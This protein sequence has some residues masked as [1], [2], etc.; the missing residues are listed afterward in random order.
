MWAGIESDASHVDDLIAMGFSGIH[1]MQDRPLPIPTKTS[2]LTN[3]SGFQTAS[4]VNTAISTAT[5]ALQT[6]SITD[7]GG[8]FSTDTVEGALQEIGAELAGVNTLIGSG[9]IT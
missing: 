2:D 5:G 6:K 7:T 8:Y 9:V 1:T 4:Q 3:D